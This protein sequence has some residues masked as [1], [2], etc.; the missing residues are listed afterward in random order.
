M[1]YLIA[2]IAA[3][4]LRVIPAPVEVQVQEGCF[5]VTEKSQ[6]RIE[7]KLDPKSGLPEEGYT[8]VVTPKRVKAVASTPA[9]LF[10]AAKTLDQL[11]EEDRIPC[12]S[13][14]DYPRFRWRGFMLDPARHFI[15]VE[16]IKRDIDLLSKYKINVFHWHLVDDQGW[17][18]EIKKYPR[19]TEVGSVRTGFDGTVHQGYYTQEEVREVVAYAAERFVTVVPEIEM[20]GHSMGAIRAYPWLSCDK[21][22]IDN[23]YIWGVSDF[24]LCPGCD[25]TFDFLDDVIS[26]VVQL[27]PSK[28]IHIGGD[29]C[30]KVRWK[31]C[32]ACQARIAAEGLKGDDKDTAEEKLQSYAVRRMEGILAK[33]GRLLIGWDEILEGGLSP[34]ATVMSWRGETGG[35][36]AAMSGHDV[37]MTPGS[38]GLYLNHGPG[39]LKAEPECQG[40]VY[41]M[42][43]TYN[44]NPVPAALSPEAA[45]HVLGI[46]GNLWGEYTRTQE[47]RDYLFFPKIFAV[48]ENAWIPQEKK[49]YPDFCRRVDI[50]CQE[51]DR[52]GINYHI[53]LPEQPGGS[54]NQIAFT[55]KAVLSFTTSRPMRMVYTLDGTEPTLESA[56]YTGPIEVSKK[57][58][59]KIASVTSYGKMSAVRSIKLQKMAP[60]PAYQLDTA[61]LQPGLRYKLVRGKFSHPFDVPLDAAWD[62]EGIIHNPR[63]ISKLIP[64][65]FTMQDPK[66]YAVQVTG[67]VDIPKD[68]VW[69]FSACFDELWIDGRRVVDRRGEVRKNYRGD[70][71]LVLE[72]GLH[73]IRIVFLNNVG[74]GWPSAYVKGDIHARE[75]G[76]RKFRSLKPEQLFCQIVSQ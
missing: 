68:G 12:V 43:H 51:L 47:F 54:C 14:K 66:F 58:V 32:P 27:F 57:G 17:R 24:V 39:D 67:Y 33:Y 65:D 69:Y 8:L 36:K 41:Y 56:T 15:P 2:L 35:I 44:Y 13:I 74:G 21:R 4:A 55:D 71:T 49:D 1:H 7:F 28:Y 9:G 63:Q 59:L 50:A 70:G 45:K 60:L 6:K 75:A 10:Y 29:E 72:K 62:E 76:D 22:Q 52:M 3:A 73:A 5:T 46:Q 64:Q 53:P 61:Q 48:A 30:P 18:L 25:S 34:G 20:P 26:E 16:E 19:L 40:H 11:R 37:I 42:S 23:F 38:G 31:S